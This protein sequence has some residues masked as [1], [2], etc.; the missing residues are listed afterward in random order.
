[1][2][3]ILGSIPGPR[4]KGKERK[5]LGKNIVGIEEK[6]SNSKRW[7]NWW[8]DVTMQDSKKQDSWIF[9]VHL[10]HKWCISKYITWLVSYNKAIIFALEPYQVMLRDHSWQCWGNHLWCRGLSWA[11]H[12]QGKALICCAVQSLQPPLLLKLPL[13]KSLKKAKEN[14][15][16]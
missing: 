11:C 15:M 6:R 8:G 7:S 12:T 16:K 14:R 9:I 3:A 4:K 5:R 1:M 2:Y 13:K 10:A